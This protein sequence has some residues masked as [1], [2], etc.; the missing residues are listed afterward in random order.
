MTIKKLFRWLKSRLILESVPKKTH[1]EIE[2]DYLK[3]L[4]EEMG[5]P[6][7]WSFLYLLPRAYAFVATSPTG[8]QCSINLDNNRIYFW[9][10]SLSSPTS[11]NDEAQMAFYKRLKAMQ[12]E[13]KQHRASAIMQK[14]M[15]G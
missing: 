8:K 15:R 5:D 4:W 1:R 6:E 13:G 14:Q 11:L 12:E 9:V 7:G 10:S 2:L 3:E